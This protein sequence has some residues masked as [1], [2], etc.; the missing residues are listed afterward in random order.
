MMHLDFDK[1]AKLV[2]DDPAFCNARLETGHT[3]LMRAA[4]LPDVRMLNLFLANGAEPRASGPTGTTALH[5]ATNCGSTE[6]VR[7]LM[8]YGADP[9]AADCR[10]DTARDFA[11]R[12]ENTSELLDALKGSGPVAKKPKLVRQD[13]CRGGG[14]VPD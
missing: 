1:A 3:V 4:A 5:I 8:A 7:L 9:E 11:G 13:A 2:R 10:G 6:A 14:V 12:V